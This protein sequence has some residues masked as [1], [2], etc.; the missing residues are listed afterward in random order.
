MTVPSYEA[1]SNA[2]REYIDS[3]GL[4]AG[5]SDD[6]WA[7]HLATITSVDR[8]QKLA[9]VSYNGRVW[10]CVDGAEIKISAAQGLTIAAGERK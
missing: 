1:A 10:S 5:C 9:T 3:N 6:G 7:F 2:V 4:G 8:K